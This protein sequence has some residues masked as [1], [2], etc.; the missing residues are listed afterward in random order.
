MRM[1]QTVG[2]I[3]NVLPM[4]GNCG[5]GLNILEAADPAPKPALVPAPAPDLDLAPVPPPA[6]AFCCLEELEVRAPASA[7]SPA[8]LSESELASAWLVPRLPVT[9]TDL[10]TWLPRVCFRVAGRSSFVLV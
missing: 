10:L 6:P 5:R 9:C 2:V 7:A 8:S 1:R 3:I 4:G